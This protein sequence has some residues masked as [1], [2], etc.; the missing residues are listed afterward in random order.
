M[1]AKSDYCCPLVGLA[2][3]ADGKER[4][5]AKG[6]CEPTLTQ[7]GAYERFLSGNAATIL[8]GTQRDYWRLKGRMDNGKIGE[9]CFAAL[10][11]YTDL[12]QYVG[13]GNSKDKTRTELIYCYYLIPDVNLTI[14]VIQQNHS[15]YVYK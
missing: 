10:S 4:D 12:V 15:M 9:I 7:Y 3:L 11:D 2:M 5:I 13:I 8:L 1:T 6:C 14:L